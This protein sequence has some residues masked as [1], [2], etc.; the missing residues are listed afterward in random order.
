LLS[1]LQRPTNSIKIFRSLPWS[2]G[3]YFVGTQNLRHCS[4]FSDRCV[5]HNFKISTRSQPFHHN[6]HAVIMLHS[7]YKIQSKLFLCFLCCLFWYFLSASVHQCSILISVH[8]L[9]LL[10]GQ[11]GE[12]AE[13]SN[14]AIFFPNF[15]PPMFQSAKQGFVL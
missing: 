10:E 9:L 3:R 4:L 2:S 1:K 15:F 14:K 5:E 13:T 8:T 6:V 12:A 11:W 7:K